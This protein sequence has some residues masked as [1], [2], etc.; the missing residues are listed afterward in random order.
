MQTPLGSQ[1]SRESDD[2]M[3]RQELPDMIRD[4]VMVGHRIIVIKLDRVSALNLADD[5]EFAVKNR[6]L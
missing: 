1:Q 6:K 4:T 3:R 2:M 5:L